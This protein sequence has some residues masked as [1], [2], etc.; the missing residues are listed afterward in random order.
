MAD[1]IIRHIQEK[2]A[3][4]G[5]NEI[6][7]QLGI[8]GGIIGIIVNVLLFAL[9]LL[10]GLLTRSMAILADAFNNLSDAL[11]SVVSLVGIHL[12]SRPADRQH[13]FGHGRIEYITAL[14]IA[15]AILEV[16]VSFLR[17]SIT[18]IRHPEPLLVHPLP[19][20]LL[21]ISIVVKIALSLFNQKVGKAA[22]SKILAATAADALMDAITTG[23]TILS[24]LIYVR[25]G[26]NVDG[27]AGLLVAF[28][29]IWAAIGIVRGT[30]EPLIG[31]EADPELMKRVR[32]LVRSEEGV[33][34]VHDLVLHNYGPT[35]VMGTVHAE[36]SKNRSFSEAHAIAD[37]AEKE[38]LRELGIQ[39]VVHID[40]ADPEDARV[41]R[42]RRKAEQV[43]QI[44]DL[45]LSLHDFQVEF[46]KEPKVSFDLEIPYTYDKKK[47]E[48][49]ARKVCDLLTVMEPGYHFEIDV[50]RGVIEE[51]AAETKGLGKSET[52]G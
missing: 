24:C 5:E 6:R 27:I 52:K 45:E 46:G 47:G 3:Q 51:A 20:V 2:Y 43:L 41:I 50:D 32:E 49:T 11:S 44:L 21:G 13:P 23:V 35:M 14:I 48:D 12:S 22:G 29:I 28:L 16:G 15:A 36:I 8:F 1:R 7:K 37:R 26:I 30:V 17:Q 25:L 39:I 34:S 10:V 18:K 38:V 4:E 19:L 31:Q 9:K 40:P 42:I 33:L